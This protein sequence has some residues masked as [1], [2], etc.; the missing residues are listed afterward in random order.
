MNDVRK[1]KLV[2]TQKFKVSFCYFTFS[3]A[4]FVSSVTGCAGCSS[5]IPG[6]ALVT[7]DFAFSFLPDCSEGA[8]SAVAFA[9]P[10]GAE[11]VLLVVVSDDAL[12]FAQHI[13]SVAGGAD[14]SLV[15]P[16]LTQ[17]AHW[18]ASAFDVDSSEDACVAVVVATIVVETVVVLS[19]CYVSVGVILVISMVIVISV[20]IVIFVVIVIVFLIV[21]LFDFSIIFIIFVII[22]F[23]LI[24]FF[25]DFVLEC[26]SSE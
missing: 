13:A 25:F 18:S 19:R 4:E 5:S 12:A 23:V 9:V 1:E 24:V 16:S 17:V 14:S 20:V 3:F 15:A 21:I 2:R 6:L 22:V 26:C 10:L 8:S 7:D 11:G